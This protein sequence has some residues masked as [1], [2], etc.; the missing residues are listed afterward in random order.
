[1]HIIHLALF[2]QSLNI[3]ISK[4]KKVFDTSFLK[5]TTINCGLQKLYHHIHQLVKIML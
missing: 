3:N 1:M 2:L 5:S 4:I